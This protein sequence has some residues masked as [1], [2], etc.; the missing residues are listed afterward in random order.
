M[1]VDVNPQTAPENLTPDNAYSILKSQAEKV[2]VT[3]NTAQKGVVTFD[4]IVLEN[5]LPDIDKSYALSVEAKNKDIIVEI[6]AR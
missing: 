5:E 6:F 1:N 4:E 2:N 3:Q